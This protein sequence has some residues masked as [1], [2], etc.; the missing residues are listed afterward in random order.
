MKLVYKMAIGVSAVVAAS[1]VV[2]MAQRSSSS[3]LRKLYQISEEGYETAQDILFPG[4]VI[5]G[6]NLRYG[7]VIPN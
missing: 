7:P 4:E 1:V 2:Y 5:E 3:K 6:K